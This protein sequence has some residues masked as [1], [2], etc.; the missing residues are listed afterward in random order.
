MRIVTLREKPRLIPGLFDIYGDADASSGGSTSLAILSL[1]FDR[2]TTL[3]STLRL[4][5]TSRLWRET[6]CRPEGSQSKDGTI[7]GL[8]MNYRPEGFSPSTALEERRC[9]L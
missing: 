9:G 8:A 4:P 3:S 2:L 5:S 7:S 1:W 6:K